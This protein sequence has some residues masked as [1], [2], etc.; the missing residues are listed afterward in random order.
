MTLAREMPMPEKRKRASL[1]TL[2]AAFLRQGVACAGCGETL[3]P[4][5]FDM[6]HIQ[7]LDALGKQTPD[8]WQALCLACHADKTAADLAR[9]RKGARIRG[10]AGQL[11]RRRELGPALVSRNDLK[12]R[13]SRPL[14]SRKF[15]TWRPKRNQA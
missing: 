8:N 2:V 10:E 5:A 1:S 11:K 12:G 13:T 6:D 3:D 7:P 4:D 14:P 15:S 9:S